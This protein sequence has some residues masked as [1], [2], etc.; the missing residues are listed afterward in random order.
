[1]SEKI[2]FKELVELIARQSEQ[3]QSSANG[4]ISELVDIIESGLKS[5]GQVS[6]SGFG[7]FELRWMKERTGTNPQTGEQITIPG[8]NKVVFKPYKALREGVNA[9]YAHLEATVIES[10]KPAKK[11]SAKVLTAPSKEVKASI[12]NSTEPKESIDD[13]IIERDHP[14]YKEK[15]ESEPAVAATV[16]SAVKPNPKLV[17][18]VQ[19]KGTF[20]WSFA[21]AGIIALLAFLLLFYII[22]RTP[23]TD[24]TQVTEQTETPA[25]PNGDAVVQPLDERAEETETPPLDAQSTQRGEFDLES[26]QVTPGQS[27][28][29]IADAELGNPYLWPLIYHL[30]QDIIDNPNQIPVTTTLQVP[31]ISDPDNLNEFERDQVAR[32]YLSLYQWNRENNPDEAR[33]FL[34]AVGVFS[35]DLFE[36]LPSE[37]DSDDLAFAVSR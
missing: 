23:E 25:L 28:W 1:M 12:V 37:V 15:K 2:T 35:I 33:F 3:S 36:N 6:I 24:Q 26:V 30:N 5:D 34:W 16:A 19:D 7:K 14:L 4:F 11:E 10:E 9:P 29:T 13:L 8:Q 27:L 18:E 20:N 17:K 32:G 31:I 22:Q 21:A